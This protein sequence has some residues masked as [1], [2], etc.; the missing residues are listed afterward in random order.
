MRAVNQSGNSA[1][2]REQETLQAHRILQLGADF[3][4]ASPAVLR[5]QR[6]D[7]TACLNGPRRELARH[8]RIVDPFSGDRV[9]EAARVASEQRPSAHTK[10]A[11]RSSLGNSK[12]RFGRGP[13]LS[14]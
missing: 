8:H 4:I 12:S 2:I 11:G 1:A 5:R 13:K 3:V 14:E 9:D 10:A 7:A 6:R